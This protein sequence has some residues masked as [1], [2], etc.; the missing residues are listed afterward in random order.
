M[1][2]I[3]VLAIIVVLIAA[4]LLYQTEKVFIKK[5]DELDMKIQVQTSTN[6]DLEKAHLRFQ[7]LSNKLDGELEFW[8]KRRTT[9]PKVPKNTRKE[10]I[11]G[12]KRK[13]RK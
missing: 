8:K 13:G 12:K 1:I 10:K 6:N 3:L 5:C 4:L 7:Q 11:R 2:S 9:L